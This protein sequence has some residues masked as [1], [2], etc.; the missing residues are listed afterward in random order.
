MDCPVEEGQIRL[1]LEKVEGIRR[2]EFRLAQ[3]TLL[4]DAPDAVV[5]QAMA[6]I[7]KA[8][9]ELQAVAAAAPAASSC[10]S[11]A[12]D[13]HDHGHGHD[14]DHDH[15]GDSLRERVQMGAALVLALLA[16]GIHF[17]APHTTP[18][19]VTS[20]AVAAAAIGLSG[21]AVYR[22]GLQALLRG[23]LNINALMTVAVTGAFL[24]GQWPEAAMVMALYTIAEWLEA[25]SADRARNAVQNLLELAPEQAEVRQADGQWQMQAVDAIALGSVFR[26]KAGE[27]IALDGEIISG[28][29]AINQ[30]SVTGESVP[31][32]KQ[33]GDNVFAG[34]INT[35][36]LLEV[37]STADAKSSTLARII[38][39]VEQAQANRAPIQGLVDRFAAVYTPAV[40]VLALGVAIVGG[41][42]LGW[43]WL[44]A[45]YKAL[46]ILVIA[47]PCALV[48]STPVTI[49]S[50]LAAAAKRGVLIKGGA[51]LEQ[52]RKLTTIAFDKTGTL[53]IGKPELQHH[54]V[55]A[56]APAQALAW[57]Q[58]LASASDH[59]V[60]QAIAQ[61]L[62]PVLQT[63]A[64]PVQDMQAAAGHGVAGKVEG[65]VLRL[66]N[67]RWLQQDLALSTDVQA[68]LQAQQ[69]QGRTVT[70]LADGTRVLALFAVADRIKSHAQE[71]IAELQ[72]LGVR[73]LMLSG[74]HSITAQ[75]IAKEA[76][77][78][79][80][81]GELLPQDKLQA[82]T[83]VQQTH[84]LTAMV[85]DGINDAP[86]LA[87]ADMGIAM[88]GAGTGIALEAADVVIM[89]DDLRRV[90]E[91]VRLS[92]HAYAVLAQN[93]ALALGIKLVFLVLTLAGMG[94]MWMAV[95]ADVGASLLVVFNGLRLLRWRG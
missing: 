23:R 55:F 24:I 73:T 54:Q 33:T 6:V 15:P 63:Q 14:H 7:R 31:V 46:V 21:F 8:G 76:G 25:R 84:G 1:A 13:H 12:H 19:K 30:A 3:R 42:L 69:A 53:T 93:I 68:L 61:G 37:R 67:A 94:T 4:V 38:A 34:T 29:S 32:D 95:F 56:E 41:T 78:A 26:V 2:L 36:G 9:F 62:Q 89:N 39:A 88:G 47:C 82:I 49:V 81:R 90:P 80:A 51:Y 66:G 40:F 48:L 83:H 20:M 17:L 44:Q 74:D 71:A 70:L 72:Q 87:Q 27:R 65:H 59:P 10:S 92:R 86:A 79:E 77:I 22:H 85:G 64:L 28:Q 18:W 5:E 60:S 52:A 57:A 11:C 35:T 75:A 16:E 45:I 91:T 58:A 43:P 50:A